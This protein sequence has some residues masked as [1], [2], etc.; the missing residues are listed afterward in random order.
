MKKNISVDEARE[1]FLSLPMTYETE[2]V[3]LPDALDRVAACDF[4][5]VIPYPPFKR[6]PFDGY[7]FRSGD[8]ADA[9]KEHPAVL[10]INQEIPC[11]FEPSADIP[12]GYAAKILTGAPIPDG[13]D[14]I[15]KFEDTEFTE[16]EVRIFSPQETHFNIIEPGE[17]FPAGKLLVPKGTVITPAVMGILASQGVA[18]IEVFKKPVL[19][20][21][22]TGTELIQPGNPLTPAKIYN[23]SMYTLQGYI[24]DIGADFLDGGIAE[25]DPAKIVAA[26]ESVYD[27]SDMIITT[28]GASVGDY[29]CAVSSAQLADGDILFWKVS[30][31]PGGAILAY[32]LRGKLVL[33]LSGNPGA[34]ALGLLYIALPYIR[35]LCGRSDL[36]PEVCTVFLKKELTKSNPKTRVMRGYLSVE[37]GTAYF[38]ENESQGSGDISSFNRCD[39]LAEIPEGSPPLSAGMPVKAYRI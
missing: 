36:F 26:I 2:I 39:L 11:G 33:S 14:I 3:S 27:D 12:S 8:T 30:L 6:S 13:A 25:D 18:K 17:D 28:G 35:K 32:T 1:L 16:T 24:K 4:A 31:K 20:V 10:K 5:A 34:A 19:S 9:T 21:I 15:L 23:S 37:D 22:N 38:I 7:A 29:G